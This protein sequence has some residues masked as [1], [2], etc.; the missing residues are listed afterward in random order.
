M[1]SK[2]ESGFTKHRPL[3][4]QSTGQKAI[5]QRLEAQ[6][7]KLNDRTEYARAADVTFN[8]L[9]DR[10]IAEEMPSRQSRKRGRKTILGTL[11]GI[12]SHHGWSWPMLI[13]ALSPS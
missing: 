1:L 2:T 11:I 6:L 3:T 13:F 7:L 10:Y 5:R 4:A 12:R 9:L 8:A